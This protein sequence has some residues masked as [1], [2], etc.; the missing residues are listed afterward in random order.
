[1]EAQTVRRHSTAEP[2]VRLRERH[3]HPDTD[4]RK[5]AEIE[6]IARAYQALRRETA[7]RYWAPEHPPVVLHRPRT[8]VTARRSNGEATANPLGSH[9]QANAVLD[10]LDVVR[11]SWEQAFGLVRSQVARRAHQGRCT[12]AERHE[13]HWLL[14]WPEHLA[15]ILAGGI[16]V[17]TGPDGALIEALA[18]ND[19][20][21]LDRWLGDTLRRARPGQPKLRHR[22]AFELDTYR[23]STRAGRFPIWLTIQGLT[24][25]RPLRIPMA[26]TDTEFLDGTANLRVGVETNRRGVQRI[27]F[28]R[29]VK[30]EVAERAG[31]GA[32]G[33]DKGANIAIVATGS[34][35]EHAR[36]F[37][38]DAGEILGRRSE[39]LFRRARSRMAA[40]ADRLA[41]RYTPSGRFH[42][43]P[44]PTGAQRRT[45]RHIRRHNLGTRRR[46]A[47]QRRAEAELM[48]VTGRA[49]RELVEA[50]PE[51]SVFYEEQLDFR[52]P[53]QRRPRR[54]NRKLNRWTKK[55]LSR[56][57]DLH[58][59][60]S[61]ARREFVSAAYTSQACPR[62]SWTD[63]N[64]RGSNAF[65]CSHCGYRGHADAVAS[66]NVL[67][68]GRDRTIPLFTPYRVVK[69]ILLE[70]HAEW[71]ASAGTDARCA[72]RG[73]GAGLPAVGPAGSGQAAA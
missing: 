44:N 1:M 35:A 57:I 55:E 52:A 70:R 39:R 62:C 63:R 18:D 30:L 22:L 21:R 14:R 49:A 28:R 6:M 37:G 54:T 27:V 29:E 13:I 51:A 71:R 69:R 65:R 20:A 60:A 43:N 16:V 45:A 61:G 38:T 2:I 58:V 50:F 72:S 7:H 3:S 68:R 56:A 73:C 41:G 10:G 59:S 31:G 33:I 19:H 25:G 64:N 46:D 26:G 66:S 47:E 4:A 67:H 23:V 36:F 9:Y 11:G 15:T 5:L 12:D 24:P 8:V 32:V 40:R 17:P 42:G 53:D 34:D 48:N